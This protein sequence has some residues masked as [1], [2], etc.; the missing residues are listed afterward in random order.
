MSAQIGELVDRL[1]EVFR[2]VFGDDGI[3]IS[4]TMTAGDVD[5]WD[6]ISHVNMLAAVEDEFK[7]R[8]TLSEVAAL[9]NVGDLLNL[10]A[11]KVPV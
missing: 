7:V 8:F 10:V 11:R 1:Q 5:G 4:P 6:S 3:N 9:K 2:D